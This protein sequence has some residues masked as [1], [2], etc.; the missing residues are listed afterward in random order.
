MELKGKVAYFSHSKSL[1][2]TDH[3]KM[4]LNRLKGIFKGKIICPNH[5]L[6]NLENPEDYAQIA[7][8][9]DLVFVWGESNHSEL[10][11][12]CFKEVEEAMNISVKVI[13]IEVNADT[14]SL[15]DVWTFHK[16]DDGNYLEYGYVESTEFASI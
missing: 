11:K 9:S 10:S 4:I 16:H 1:F 6:G 8:N 3:E 2:G 15:R 7:S 12:G 13:L 5:D 14:L